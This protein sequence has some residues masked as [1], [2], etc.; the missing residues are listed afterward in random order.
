MERSTIPIYNILLDLPLNDI[1]KYC[2]LNSTTICDDKNF[3]HQKAFNDFNI[4]PN[5]FDA[6][7]LEPKIRYIQLYSDKYQICDVGYENFIPVNVCLKRA[8]INNEEN[9]ITYFIEKGGNIK[10]AFKGIGITGN[11]KLFDKLIEV[12]PS[13]KYIYVTL[14]NAVK[15]GNKSF[16]DFLRI[17]WGEYFREPYI[18]KEV[19]NAAIEKNGSVDIVKYMFKI[20]KR[21]DLYLA[22]KG[23]H[24]DLVNYFLQEVQALLPKLYSQGYYQDSMDGAAYGGHFNLLNQLIQN[25]NP[26][27][28]EIEII[29]GKAAEGGHLDIVNDLIFRYPSSS[30]M[31]E[32][33]YDGSKG[34]HI[35]IIEYAIGNGAND[36]NHLNEATT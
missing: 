21:N 31:V 33:L 35:N 14:R 23:G 17:R 30:N 34:G 27:D 5:E 12:Y 26:S 15:K 25:F 24:V 19:A 16:L 4:L 8:T 2:K 36:L 1:I 11:K 20:I 22:A 18:Y 28:L 3:W 6:I 9:L 10:A 29:I 7:N 32:V 13:I